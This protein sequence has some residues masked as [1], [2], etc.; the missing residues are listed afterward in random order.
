M[1]RIILI[2]LLIIQNHLILRGQNLRVTGG[3]KAV[4]ATGNESGTIDFNKND[5]FA[6]AVISVNPAPAIGIGDGTS[7]ANKLV[8]GSDTNQAASAFTLATSFGTDIV[9]DLVVTGTNTANVDVNG[10]KIYRD[11]GGTANEWDATDTL[12]GTASFAG[13]TATFTGIN[14]GAYKI[15]HNT[16]LLT[17][18]VR[19]LQT[20][21]H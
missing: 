12:V 9:A 11:N 15:P 5:R 21:R 10:V 19:L 17:I 4:T 8:K 14:L 13:A 16:S 1:G 2:L 7:P 3:Y 6:A 18:S 20:G